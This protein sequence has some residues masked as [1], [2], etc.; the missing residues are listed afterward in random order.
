MNRTLGGILGA[1]LA[2]TAVTGCGSQARETKADP[3]PVQ[4][5]TSTVPASSP[6]TTPVITYPERGVF[7]EHASE[8]DKLKGAPESFKE[9]VASEAERLQAAHDCKA[10]VGVTVNKIM[11]DF[12]SGGISECGGY[13]A[14]WAV[15]KGE[16][17]EIFATQSGIPC[18]DLEA[19]GAPKELIDCDPGY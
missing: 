11:G 13:V 6:A 14:V 3:P 17:K 9:F 19:K 5:P 16:W 7:V 18:Q 15:E 2:L 8:V 12:A 4:A 1:T 10:A